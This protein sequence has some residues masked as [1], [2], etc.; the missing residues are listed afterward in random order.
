MKITLEGSPEEIRAY[1]EKEP[2]RNKALS[3]QK[4]IIK[5]AVAESIR[6]NE[7]KVCFLTDDLNA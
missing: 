7:Q 6:E 1:M 2:C 4:K 5:K 3:K